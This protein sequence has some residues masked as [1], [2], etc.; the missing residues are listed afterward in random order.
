[1]KELNSYKITLTTLE[2]FRIGTSRDVMSA[3]DNPVAMI[4][5]K[6]VVQGPTLKG[7]LRNKIEEYLIDNYS[8]NDLMKPCIPSSENT[9]SADEKILI[10]DGRY[11]AGGVCKYSS[12]DSRNRSSS[13]CPV[14]YFLGAN[15]LNG[16]VRVPYLYTESRPE[17]L[18]S[19]RTDRA[20]ATVVERT[21]RN[22]QIIADNIIFE[23]TLEILTEDSIN[24]W[25]LGRMREIQDSS[26]LDIWLN[27]T[28]KKY[29]KKF[30]ELSKDELISEFI[31]ERL[32]GKNILGGF[33]SKGCG[34]VE[35][36]VN[37]LTD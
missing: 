26:R 30:I 13:I 19:V 3:F 2:P 36:T 15:G 9:L 22:Y 24:G 11:R 10:K 12:E 21:N 28:S 34:K 16:F 5:G 18:Y 32:I 23:G 27:E 4:G 37:K 7:F 31:L 20:T 8:G 17:E 35:I 29:N 6:V 14:C 33:K 25:T 1:V